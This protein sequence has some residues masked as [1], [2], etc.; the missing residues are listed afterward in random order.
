MLHMLTFK[1]RSMLQMKALAKGFLL[2]YESPLE[3]NRAQH[4]STSSASE[5]TNLLSRGSTSGTSV[6][7][8][9]RW[10]RVKTEDRGGVRP[11]W[12]GSRAPS[13]RRPARSAIRVVQR[14][15]LAARI[16]SWHL[17]LRDGCTGEAYAGGEAMR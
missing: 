3:R 12:I 15:V 16:T 4:G 14:P 13:S 8:A 5:A 9:Q 7:H 17:I 2:P 6:Q 11:D 10:Y 1:R